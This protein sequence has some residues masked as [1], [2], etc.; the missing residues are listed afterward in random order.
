LAFCQ[1]N[2][3]PHRWDYQLIGLRSRHRADAAVVSVL[4][5]G[6]FQKHLSRQ[7]R[8]VDPPDD[9]GFLRRDVEERCSVQSQLPAGGLGAGDVIELEQRIPQIECA[10]ANR[11]ID[12][13]TARSPSSGLAEAT[14]ARQSNIQARNPNL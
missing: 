6:C 14:K 2:R 8:I 10:Q 9:G 12:H 11:G 13:P 5:A 4:V 1:S 7:A 3:H